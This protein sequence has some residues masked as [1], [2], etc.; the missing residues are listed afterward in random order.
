[1]K[2]VLRHLSFW[3]LWFYGTNFY[4]FTHL[5]KKYVLTTFCSCIILMGVFYSTLFIS[6]SYNT[7]R[8]N[9]T[10][11]DDNFFFKVIRPFLRW[12]VAIVLIVLFAVVLLFW[13]VENFFHSI[14]KHP[15]ISTKFWYYAEVRFTRVAFYAALAFAIADK[16]IAVWVRDAKILY[17]QE[18]MKI[19]V[20]EKNN[21]INLYNKEM[22][23][24]KTMLKEIKDRD[25]ENGT[26]G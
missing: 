25:S 22:R 14:G 16:Q 18:H 6:R 3:V 23:E 9:I 10:E 8:A 20:R 4:T 12:D 15:G 13:I 11:S 2:T 17:Q 1:M 24:M 7:W 19:V 21:V 5:E 26:D